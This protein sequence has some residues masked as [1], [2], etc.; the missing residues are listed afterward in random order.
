[1]AETTFN[2]TDVVPKLQRVQVFFNNNEEAIKQN[3]KIMVKTRED[4]KSS[5]YKIVRVEKE[6]M[7]LA[8]LALNNANIPANDDLI[9]LF[10][11]NY[12]RNG[13]PIEFL[14]NEEMLSKINELRYKEQMSKEKYPL[15]SSF[16]RLELEDGKEYRVY[17]KTINE[18]RLFL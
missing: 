1:M 11:R 13:E 3:Y 9:R 10:V 5:Y 6:V 14:S 15:L 2:S 8:E 16:G 18:R 7:D 12:Y 17:T 4:E